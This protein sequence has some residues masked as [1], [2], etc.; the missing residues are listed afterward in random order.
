[1]DAATAVLATVPGA[2]TESAASQLVL[3]DPTHVQARLVL[4]RACLHAMDHEGA[5]EHCRHILLLNP[6]HP[7]ALRLLEQCAFDLREFSVGLPTLSEVSAFDQ[8]TPAAPAPQA[9]RSD[10]RPIPADL[11]GDYAQRCRAWRALGP[12]HLL[13]QMVCAGEGPAIVLKSPEPVQALGADGFPLPPVALTMGYGA[14]DLNHYLECARRSHTVLQS[15]LT[16]QDIHLEPGQAMLDWGC[17]AGR[18]VRTFGAEASRGC[19]VWGCDVDTAAI[20]WAQDHLSPPFRF[21]NCAA[22][23][24]LPFP[25]ERVRFLYGLSVFTH[26]VVFRDLWLLELARILQPGGCAVL[27]IH[28][29]H[30]WRRFQE[31][32]FPPW[33]PVELH[34]HAQLPAEVVEIRGSRWDA[35]YTF[36][37]ADYIRRVWG[38]HLDVVEIKPGADSYQAA[39]VLRKS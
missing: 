28:D 5:R 36:F 27:T 32:G 29:E 39:V 21:F 8:H 24:H 4:A 17:A 16:E 12:E 2:L 22:L 20:E 7:E 30:C 31:K 6:R 13:Q 25:D 33:V 34:R 23:P 26:L 10:D 11:F 9:Q 1:M 35:C 18:V 3:S 14:G 38:R 37:H 19:H 15:I